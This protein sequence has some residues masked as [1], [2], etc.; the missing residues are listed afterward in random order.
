M[1][2]DKP[3]GNDSANLRRANISSKHRRSQPVALDASAVYMKACPASVAATL[4]IFV[5]HAL[6]VGRIARSPFATQYLDQFALCDYH[7]RCGIAAASSLYHFLGGLAC[8]AIQFAFGTKSVFW[9]FYSANVLADLGMLS[10]KYVLASVVASSFLTQ[11]ALL[12]YGEG[13][14]EMTAVPHKFSNSHRVK[15]HGLAQRAAA[16]VGPWIGVLIGDFESCV[17]WSLILTIAASSLLPFLLD[18]CGIGGNDVQRALTS[19][20]NI[21]PVLADLAPKSAVAFVVL[22][23]FFSA[24]GFYAFNMLLSLSLSH[25]SPWLLAS[26]GST[27][28]IGEL[29]AIKVSF[30]LDVRHSDSGKFIW[31]STYSVAS[32]AL[33]V[34]ALGRLSA[35]LVSSTGGAAS[36]GVA[37]SSFMSVGDIINAL[38]IGVLLFSLLVSILAATLLSD[39]QSQVMSRIVQ[40]EGGAHIQYL[41]RA[42]D[43]LAGVTGPL[44]IRSVVAQHGPGVAMAGIFS[45]YIMLHLFIHAGLSR[46]IA[47]FLTGMCARHRWHHN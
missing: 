39:L 20:G 47:P 36:T 6:D 13:L 8:P 41:E 11:N 2:N 21:P 43:A 16:L 1:D 35:F 19:D 12:P 26:V 34:V 37:G 40:V 45:L 5:A 27:C 29:V 31:Q 32:V 7:C 4:G 30:L 10:P 44:Y 18:S 23:R 17:W 24:F 9:A 3:M 22:W 33:K 42:T 25:A 14:A 46:I 28:G 15:M 38:D